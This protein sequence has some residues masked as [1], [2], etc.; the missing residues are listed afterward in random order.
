MLQ[1]IL[2]AIHKTVLV[3]SAVTY[4]VEMRESVDPNADTDNGPKLKVSLY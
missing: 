4:G 1:K 2:Q 3:T